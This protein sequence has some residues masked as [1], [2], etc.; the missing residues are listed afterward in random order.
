MTAFHNADGVGGVT[1]RGLVVAND[2]LKNAH[3]NVAVL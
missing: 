2:V 3:T 1:A